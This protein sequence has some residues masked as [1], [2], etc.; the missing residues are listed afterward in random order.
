MSSFAPTKDNAKKFLKTGGAYDGLL[1]DNIKAWKAMHEDPASEDMGS[2]P[3]VVGLNDPAVIEAKNNA[4]RNA[5]RKSTRNRTML[6]DYGMG[7]S[8]TAGRKTLMGS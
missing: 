8:A 7:E 1:K 4:L 6:T 2:P 3:K 5:I